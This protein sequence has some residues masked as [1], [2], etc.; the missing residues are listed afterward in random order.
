MQRKRPLQMRDR[1]GLRSRSS[2]LTPGPEKPLSPGPAPAKQGDS[3]RQVGGGERAPLSSCRFSFPDSPW[4]RATKKVRRAGAGLRLE[5]GLGWFLSAPLTLSAG[6]HLAEARLGSPAAA[7]RWLAG[8]PR[9]CSSPW[10][11]SSLK[12]RHLQPRLFH[13]EL[14]IKPSEQLW[15]LA[16][17]QR[18]PWSSR[19]RDAGASPGRGGAPG[20][21]KPTRLGCGHCSLVSQTLSAFFQRAGRLAPDRPPTGSQRSRQESGVRS[22]RKSLQ[23][24]GTPLC[25][26]TQRGSTGCIRIGLKH[27]FSTEDIFLE[28]NRK[29]SQIK[30]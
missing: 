17:E 22:S 20:L 29:G 28:R 14:L 10:S 25:S 2:F 5:P 7:P 21:Q 30:C 12:L 6:P 23:G 11:L 19:L 13:P 3:K 9:G 24:L 18:P 15:L 1:S 4:A 16:Q 8:Q 26:Q 27:H